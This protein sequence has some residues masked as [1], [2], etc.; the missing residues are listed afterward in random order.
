MGF[1][2]YTLCHAGGG[3]G[4]G[5]SDANTFGT[6]KLIDRPFWEVG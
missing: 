2:G 6:S 5:L 1:F 4:K 3:V